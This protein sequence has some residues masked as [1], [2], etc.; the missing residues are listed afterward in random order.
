[1]ASTCKSMR[2]AYSWT[3]GGRGSLEEPWTELCPPHRHPAAVTAHRAHSLA[4]HPADCAVMLCTVSRSQQSREH[5]HSPG[6]QQGHPRGAIPDP[7]ALI[8]AGKKSEG[9]FLSSC[10]RLLVLCTVRCSSALAQSVHKDVSV[11]LQ[12]L[13]FS[14]I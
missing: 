5:R 10:C 3:Q 11:H 6:S 9:S 13:S 2:T 7:Q 14:V 1:M 12:M 4:A 8:I